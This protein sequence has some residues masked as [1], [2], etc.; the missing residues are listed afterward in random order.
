MTAVVYVVVLLLVACTSR[1]V[2]LLVG[3]RR[4]QQWQCTAGFTGDEATCP[5]F[6][7][8]VVRPKMRDIMAGMDEKDRECCCSSASPLYLTVTCPVFVL[9][10]CTGLWTLLGD[11][12]RNGF[13][14]LLSSVRQWIHIRRQS[15][16]AFG[17]IFYV[18]VS[19]L[20]SHWKSE[21][22][23]NKQLL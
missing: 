1:C 21:H 20:A 14:M 7:F 11:D 5:V 2:P 8:P 22:Y 12:F 9:L 16:V 4:R 10:R 3:F 13:R 17:R 23:F 19:R 15:T 6:S 18:T